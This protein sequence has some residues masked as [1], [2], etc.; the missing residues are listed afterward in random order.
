V[1]KNKGRQAGSKRAVKWSYSGWATMMTCEYQYYGKYILGIYEEGADDNPSILRGNELHKK[2]ENY[3]LGKINGVP[4]EF[5]PFSE[6]LQGLKKAKPI[7]E[8]YWGV[9]PNWKPIKWNSWVV[10]KMD[11]AVLPTERDN[12]LWV[13][14]LK[15]GREYPKHKDQ[16]SL[17]ACIGYAQYPNVTR[18]NVEF[19]YADQGIIRDYEFKPKQLVR[20]TEKWIKEGEKLLTPKKKYIPSPSED[21]CRWCPIRSDRQGNCEAWKKVAGIKTGRLR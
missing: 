9:D 20:A 21:N 16:A 8:Q 18:V 17:G 13:Q 19:W 1:S 10:F 2:Q 4:R 12:T 5:L 7:V 3:L 14:D 11:A 15:T 6:E